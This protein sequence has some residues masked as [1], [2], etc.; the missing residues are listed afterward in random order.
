MRNRSAIALWAL[1]LVA[2]PLVSNLAT[3]TV[4]MPIYLVPWIW[5]GLALLAIFAAMQIYFDLSAMR[6][7]DR[8][9]SENS[10]A[11]PTTTLRFLG[12]RLEISK[13]NVKL[14]RWGS[15]PLIVPWSEVKDI[16]IGVGDDWLGN[17]ADAVALDSC[18][19]V[20]PLPN[21]YLLT[22]DPSMSA[23]RPKFD[24][25][26]ILDLERVGIPRHAVEAALSLHRP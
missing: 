13:Q 17:Y 18:L 7:T 21:S 15:R 22:T 4:S 25:I 2:F 6:R 8:S 10:D 11:A 24:R 9:G 23:Y 16:H 12:G 14:I 26:Q 1:A 19:L 20:Q 3:N 5:C